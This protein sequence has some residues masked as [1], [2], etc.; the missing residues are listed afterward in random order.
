MS[1]RGASAAAAGSDDND[2]TARQASAAATGKAGDPANN[3]VSGTTGSRLSAEMDSVL[4]DQQEVDKAASPPT[5]E[6]PKIE[7]PHLWEI[8]NNPD[9]AAKQAHLI[10]T[11]YDGIFYPT[12]YF[13]SFVKAG[14][15]PPGT[16]AFNDPANPVIQVQKQRADLYD[17]LVE[18]GM[19]P[20]E[21]IKE[22][23]SFNANL[24]TS[25][26]DILDPSGYYPKDHYNSLQK[27]N[28]E[29]LEQ[30][31]LEAQ[32]QGDAATAPDA[33]NYVGPLYVGERN[34]LEDIANDPAF[35]ADR[36]RELGT[37]RQL[38][39]WDES[40]MP[41]NGD[42]ASVWTAF[43]AKGDA[44]VRGEE[45]V[46]R[47]R[48]AFYDKML[49]DGVP[50]A[51]IYREL[52]KFNANLPPSHGDSLDQS[53][54]TQPG[55]WTKWN[56]A[57]L[58]FLNQAMDQAGG[59][60]TAGEKSPSSAS[61]VA[62]QVS[63]TQ[64]TDQISTRD[65]SLF[66]KLNYVSESDRKL[67]SAMTGYNVDSLGGFTDK[68]GKQVYPEDLTQ[69]SLRTFQ[70][71]LLGARSDRA[72]DPVVGN[73]ITKSEFINLINQSRAVAT[74]MGEKFN[75]DLLVRG[76]AYLEKLE[77]NTVT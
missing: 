70:M 43:A 14:K 76:L 66:E 50:S 37:L 69:H 68:N 51:E 7:S 19:S 42:P 16:F 57:R 15:P 3:A 28:L 61:A 75:E 60:N 12:E 36:A 46:G 13:E 20:I 71:L 31:T 2:E 45:M 56:Q 9:Y 25:F 54:K 48:E 63:Q 59:V 4:L 8:A 41:K 22:I 77:V 29:L 62:S 52:L 39:M 65:T 40:Q 1:A 18:K 67:L 5:Q 11:S 33:D 30:Y 10:G 17:S 24:P 58:D 44:L 23:Y 6:K 21:I 55:G 73:H 47:K 27:S 64:E 49:A 53:G 38:I 74:S 32:E 72:A 35:A 34:S 26:T